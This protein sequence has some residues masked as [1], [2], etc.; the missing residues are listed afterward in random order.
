MVFVY[1]FLLFCANLLAWG[2]TILMAPG[3]WI[4]LG[5]AILY[6]TVLPDQ[7]SPR[8]NWWVVG[9]AFG[10]AV[11]GEILEFAA[12]AVGAA[13]KG[14]STRGAVLAIAGAFVGSIVGAVVGIP[15][16]VVGS[17]VA[18]VGGGALGAF[19][20]AYLGEAGLLHH[21]RVAIGKGALIGKLLGT[22]GKLAV[23]LIMLVILTID[24]LF[25]LSVD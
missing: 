3:N 17:V 16:P 18:A 14:G 25:D 5:F 15:I 4:M 22:A 12:G 6:L 11:I 8:L 13:Q 24:S 2:T 21:E 19:A 20:G 7:Y 10:L 1:A 23:G 9:I